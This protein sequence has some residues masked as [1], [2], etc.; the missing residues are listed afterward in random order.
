MHDR[1]SGSLGPRVS[2]PT[3]FERRLSN[4]ELIE[5]FYSQ[6]SLSA[7]LLDHATDGF[8]PENIPHTYLRWDMSRKDFF[9]IEAVKFE[10]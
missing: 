3:G 10:I 4:S 6:A 9:L 1:V 2:D 7:E 5:K 8:F